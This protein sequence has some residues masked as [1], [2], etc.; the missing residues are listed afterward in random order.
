[1]IG[2]YY[3][4]MSCV[5]LT[6]CKYVL[7]ISIFNSAND[8]NNFYL[9]CFFLDLIYKWV[10]I[11]LE[12]GTNQQNGPRLEKSHS[13]KDNPPLPPRKVWRANLRN[14]CVLTSTTVIWQGHVTGHREWKSD[15]VRHDNWC[16]QRG[17]N[18]KKKQ[19]LSSSTCTR[20]HAR[21]MRSVD[22]WQK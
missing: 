11:Q 9:I 3:M 22:R 2:L 1:M 19:N 7:L 4:H 8:N 10:Y 21:K 5:K 15:N 14:G 6:E 20:P 12:R 17:V 18:C 13:A 16:N